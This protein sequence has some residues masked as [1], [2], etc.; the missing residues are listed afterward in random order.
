MKVF[1]LVMI[2]SF[3]LTAQVSA[4]TEESFT[5][6][7]SA[8]D[9]WVFH[10]FNGFHR[11]AA[12]VLNV[13][14]GLGS[15]TMG[16]RNGGFEIMLKQGLGI[17]FGVGGVLLTMLGYNALDGAGLEGLVTVWIFGPVI[18][19]GVIMASTGVVFWVSGL[20]T[21]IRRPFVYQQPVKTAR[22]SDV[23]NWTIGLAPDTEGRLT[24]M[25]SFT[26]HF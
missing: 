10:E 19:T 6:E 14:L 22:L 18:V 26:A 16:D 1:M 24:G 12:S 4:Q 21:G 5:E 25:L 20:I 9:Q 11:F 17:G 7:Q 2:L 23:S 3:G 15:F 13:G 8:P